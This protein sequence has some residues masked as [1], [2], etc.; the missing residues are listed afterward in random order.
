MLD[1]LSTS[2]EVSYAQVLGSGVT[3]LALVWIA[4]TLAL[5]YQGAQ[6]A[7]RIYEGIIERKRQQLHAAHDELH[8]CKRALG[9]RPPRAPRRD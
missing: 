3:I 5:W 9:Q 4:G 7:C 6:E 1:W 8:L 2:M